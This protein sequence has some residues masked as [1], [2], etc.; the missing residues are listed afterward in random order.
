MGALALTSGCGAIEKNA[1]DDSKEGPV[2][3]TI[4]D[5]TCEVSTASVPSGTTTFTLTNKGTVRNEFEILASDKLRIIGER[6]NLGPGTSVEYTVNLEPGSYVTACKTN[7]IGALVGSKEF[8]VRDSGK[9]TQVSAD[10]KKLREEAVTNYNAYI[11]DQVGQL[12]EATNEFVAAYKKGDHERARELYP[13]ARQYYERIEPTAEQFGDIDPALDERYYDFQQDPSGDNTWTGW[14]VLEADLW[15]QT[16]TVAVDG[17]QT[18]RP[19]ALTPK[20]REKFADQLVAD[21]KKLYDE[22]YAKGFS[23]SLDDI[24]NGAIGLLEEV[25]TSKIS[26]EE[27]AFS[28]TDLWDFQANVEGAQVA[29]GN[30]AALAKKKN[31]ELAKQIETRLKEL[32]AALDEYK[33]GNGYRSYDTVGD[34]ERKDLSDKVNA[35]RKPL[36][37][38]TEA[39]LT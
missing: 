15:P 2:K 21:T 12:V 28:H 31:P 8:T 3:V 16:Q 19:P 33:E 26:G 10:E 34:S 29:Y 30:V 32:T 11:R 36:A 23:V 37:Q 6:E 9:G 18:P 39:I 7:M 20:Q 27:E 13:R 38:L 24:S 14:H 22:V 25:A 35:L 4:T 1:A 5:D 17:K